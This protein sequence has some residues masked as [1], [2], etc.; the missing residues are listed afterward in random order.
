MN[1]HTD[2][3]DGISDV[4]WRDS[5]AAVRAILS[6]ER[7]RLLIRF[8]WFAAVS[9]VAFALWRAVAG[10]LPIE[11]RA[12]L[13]LLLL[14]VGFWISE[15]IPAFAVGLFII[16]FLVFAFGTNFLLDEPRD[17]TP[18]VDTWSSPVIWIMLGGFVLA[19]GMSRTGLDR[20]LLFRAIRPA[21][22]RPDRVLLAIMLAAAVASM[23]IS[24]TSTTVL[25]VGAVLPMVRRLG[26]GDPFG[27]SLMVAIPLAASV[28]GMGTIIGSS[29]NAIAA[30][31]TAQYGTEVDFVSWMVIGV[32]PALLLVGVAW[33]FL[34]RIHPARSDSVSLDFGDD[35]GIDLPGRRENLI[36]SGTAIATVAMWMTAPLH[37]IHAAA[38]SLIPIVVFS[39]TQILDS[40]RLRNLPWDTLMLIAGG[41]SLGAAVVNSG[42]ADRIASGLS[43]LGYFDSPLP[44]IAGLAFVT[45][46]L[47]NFMSN[48]ATVAL[49]L[50]V[51]VA[52]LPGYE[53]EVCL[54]L[55]LSASCALLLPVSTPP[56]AIVHATG[57]VQTRDFRP[58]GLLIGVLG[59]VTAIVWV[60]IVAGFIVS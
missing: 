14:A 29:P 15:A 39:M 9:I 36:V 26:P 28:G 6:G 38:V 25:L 58:G 17:V 32:P 40:N 56:N 59:P 21:G 11:E 22:T 50:P 12:V 4:G 44:G 43:F 18:Y 2:R 47:S 1:D 3:Q 31:M 51:A 10:H 8:L 53:V 54:V 27:R 19:D 7:V 57:E 42:L 33:F 30:G 20:A 23:F 5:R 34:C 60:T 35:N 55:G 16:G 24:N 45:V 48:T 41:L 46:V 52:I 49:L 37:G 13:L